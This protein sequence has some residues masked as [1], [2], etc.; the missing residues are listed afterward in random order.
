M[1]KDKRLTGSLGEDIVAIYLE[2]NG[3]VIVE[4]NFRFKR[5]GEIDIIARENEFLCFIEVKCRTSNAFG[6]PS[7]AVTQSKQEN[8]RKL[9]CIYMNSR[10]LSNEYLRFDVAEV[11]LCSKVGKHKAEINYIRNAF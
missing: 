3:F 4:R 5:F 9:A 11:M 10:N 8:I 7:E 1:K 2:R 6:T